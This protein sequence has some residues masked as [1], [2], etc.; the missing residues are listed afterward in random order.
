MSTT[1]C[2]YPAHAAESIPPSMA[3]SSATTTTGRKLCVTCG[4]DV[5]G[6]PRMKDHNGKY[7]C[8][9]CGKADQHK[10]RFDAG[11]NC[12]MC[13]ESFTKTQLT[14]L[15]GQRLCRGCLKKKYSHRHAGS[16]GNTTGG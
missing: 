10:H 7:W 13:G 8:M 6:Q 11:G 5:T 14:E 1:P 9:N 3:S 2:H 12:F 15:D 4:R 16:S